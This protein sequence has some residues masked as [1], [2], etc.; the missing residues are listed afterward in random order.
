MKQGRR[1]SSVGSAQK[2]RVPTPVLQVDSLA[3]AADDGDEGGAPRARRVVIKKKSGQDEEPPVPV[4]R[5]VD[6]TPARRF[7]APLPGAP[8]LA[9]VPTVAEDRPEEYDLVWSDVVLRFCADDDLVGRG[10]SGMDSACEPAAGLRGA[11]PH[12]RHDA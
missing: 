7:E 4:F 3:P 6:A 9:F 12:Q 10:G 11:E 5:T 8:Y 1:R 2:Q